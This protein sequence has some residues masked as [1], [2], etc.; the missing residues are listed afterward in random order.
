MSDILG[1]AALADQLGLDVFA[2]GEHHSAGFF[3]SSPAVVLA[4]A[5]ART[6]AI[7]LASATMLIGVADLVRVYEGSPP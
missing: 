5:A 6:A 2:V 1:Y 3:T 4:A 7:R